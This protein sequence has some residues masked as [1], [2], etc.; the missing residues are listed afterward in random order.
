MGDAEL[1]ARFEAAYHAVQAHTKLNEFNVEVS[2]QAGRTAPHSHRVSALQAFW[3]GLQ[4]REGG[5]A[6]G[7]EGRY[8]LTHHPSPP[9]SRPPQGRDG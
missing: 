1:G 7:S 6:A 9:P 4:V 2:M 8:D 5:D 3:P